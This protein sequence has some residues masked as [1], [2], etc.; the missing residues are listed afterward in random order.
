MLLGSKEDDLP[1]CN[2]SDSERVL[3]TTRH[4]ITSPNST[5]IDCGAVMENA[6]ML[7]IPHTQLPLTQNIWGSSNSKDLISI[8]RTGIKE[9]LANQEP[10]CNVNQHTL[11]SLEQ[12]SQTYG[13]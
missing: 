8:L 4:L 11:N 2:P 13:E 9:L 10:L 12:K 6:V 1:V 7:A 3:D 5:S